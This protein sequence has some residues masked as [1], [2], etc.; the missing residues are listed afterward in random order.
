MNIRDNKYYRH[1]LKTPWPYY[2]GAVILAVLNIAIFASS[3]K[4][5]GVTS[6]FALWGTWIYETLGGSVDTWV[7]YA[8]SHGKALSK[9]LLANGGSIRNIGIIVGALLATLL[10]SEFKIKKIKSL[11]QMVAA[12]LGG[13]LMGYGARI[14]FGCNIGALFSGVASMALSGWIYLAFMFLGAFV[15]SKLL[16]KFFM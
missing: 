14:A 6:P 15:G 4:P 11:R 12:I 10:A 16:V 13:L 1:F 3:G 8:G 5:W 7:Y 2:A 9:G